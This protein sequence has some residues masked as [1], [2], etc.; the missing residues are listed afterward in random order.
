MIAENSYRVL[1]IDIPHS[2]L[3]V[4][5]FLTHAYEAYQVPMASR[6]YTPGMT[7]KFK[8]RSTRAIWFQGFA[9]SGSTSSPRT[10][11]FH[12]SVRPEPVE[13]PGRQNSQRLTVY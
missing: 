8:K 3:E 13:G 12:P 5:A 9:K 6:F 11:N 4:F 2:L 7:G 10:D 1:S